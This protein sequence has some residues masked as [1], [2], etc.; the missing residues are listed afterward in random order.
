MY[1][2]PRHQ[3]SPLGRCNHLF[4]AL[5]ILRRAEYDVHRHL[6]H[7]IRQGEAMTGRLDGTN[8]T[9][10]LRLLHFR[11]RPPRINDSL[12]HAVLHQRHSLSPH[13]FAIER[14]AHL[15]RMRHIVPDVD[16]LSEKLFPDPVVEERSLVQN[17]HSAKIPEHE[18]G[19]VEYG[20]RLQDHRVLPRRNL[21]RTRRLNA[22]F[23]PPFRLAASD[24]GS[25]RRVNSISAS[26]KNP[27]PAS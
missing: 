26:R 4:H 19:D 23:A 18:A 17:R 12:H 9:R 16:V 3:N 25:S 13:A 11:G 1:H 10:V 15:Q 7:F 5:R 27:R 21:S 6:A 14:R 22:P 24:P 2:K 8:F 20:R